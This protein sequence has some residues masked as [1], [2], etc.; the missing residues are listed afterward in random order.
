MT[1]SRICVELHWWIVLGD[2]SG[3]SFLR[4]VFMDRRNFTIRR[5][6][7]KRHR[8]RCIKSEF[9]FFHSLSRYSYPFSSSKGGYTCRKWS[10]SNYWRES[11]TVSPKNHW[12]WHRGKLNQSKLTSGIFRP[13]VISGKREWH[14][15]QRRIRPGS[16]SEFNKK[17]FYLH[18]LERSFLVTKFE[19]YH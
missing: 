13:V 14:G 2:E 8:K 6:I 18:C 3:A 7:E 10:R 4:D 17:R 9:T 11:Q 15:K 5:R 1:P 19:S 12:D 16:I